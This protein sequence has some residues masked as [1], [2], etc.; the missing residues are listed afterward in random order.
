MKGLLV[1]ATG[2]L[3]VT[4]IRAQEPS[5]PAEPEAVPVATSGT[6]P[7][8]VA[9]VFRS[10]IDVVALNVVV[11]DPRE[12][13]VGG[14]ASSDFAVFEDGIKQDVSFFAASDVALDLAILLDTSA[15]MSDKMGIMQRA[16]LG[17]ART[18]R[19]GDRALIV[20]IKDATRVLHALDADPDGVTAAIRSTRA[21]GGTGLFNGLY[22]TYKQ[23][24][25]SRT[26]EG[27]EMRRQAIVVLS[28]GQDTTSIMSFDDVMDVA[29]QAGIATYTITLRSP[30]LTTFEQA[31]GARYFSEAEFSM[32]QLA[33]ETGGQAYFPLQIGE[34]NN[35]YASIAKEL[36]TQY[37]IGYTP[38]TL[39][40][41]GRFRRIVVQVT[42]HP[43]M[44]IR[45]RSGYTPNRRS[46]VGA[47]E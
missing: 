35:V 37:A 5:A 12:R 29:K 8:A 14:L 23:L 13:L 26:A 24:A 33:R 41:D 27:Q 10:S 11:T 25:K 21:G 40:Q 43:D 18:L 28:D 31:R 46:P 4:G 22:M 39:H 42:D 16:A 19:P 6:L 45:T 47:L 20:D 15:S 2:L 32:R 30:E 1:L 3:L 17:F 9:P 36:S 44:R 34:L 38:K 7:P